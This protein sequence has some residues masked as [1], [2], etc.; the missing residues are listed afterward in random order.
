MH[1]KRNA[2]WQENLPFPPAVHLFE[3]SDNVMNA[4]ACSAT[5][6]EFLQI[7]TSV[8][9][10][11]QKVTSGPVML[12]SFNSPLTDA[13]YGI[14]LCCLGAPPQLYIY[15]VMKTCAQEWRGY[16]N[17]A[18]TGGSDIRVRLWCWGSQLRSCIMLTDQQVWTRPEVRSD[19]CA[20]KWA[21]VFLDA[22]AHGVWICGA[23]QV[24]LSQWDCQTQA[25]L[26][27]DQTTFSKDDSWP[28]GRDPFWISWSLYPVSFP[29]ILE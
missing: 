1:F 27:E 5:C 16:W 17:T 19:A 2:L 9:Q 26:W 4:G 23:L 18:H 21:C 3:K 7:K 24:S 10:L 20:R 15:Y 14:Q 12:W 11:K 22:R 25:V 29:G 6:D 8:L 28:T 13:I